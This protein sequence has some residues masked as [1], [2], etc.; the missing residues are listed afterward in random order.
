MLAKRP[1]G[2]ASVQLKASKPSRHRLRHR[3]LSSAREGKLF[4]EHWPPPIASILK[5]LLLS[6]FLIFLLFMI[7]F[8]AICKET[9]KSLTCDCYVL[10]VNRI[11]GLVNRNRVYV[12][13]M[14]NHYA[15]CWSVHV[16]KNTA[17]SF[18]LFCFKSCYELYYEG[19]ELVGYIRLYKV[20]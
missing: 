4:G 20:K 16:P 12:L 14:K 3:H 10:K 18:V 11:G 15:H 7:N 2:Q 6:S 17:F 19:I 13:R 5:Q 1:R 9:T 8:I